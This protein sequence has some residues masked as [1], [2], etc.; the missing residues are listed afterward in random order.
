MTARRQAI[1]AEYDNEIIKLYDTV[2]ETTKA[3]VRRME[4][5]DPLSTLDFVRDVVCNV[6]PKGVGDDD[7]IFQHGCDSLQA[8]WIRNSITHVLR[9]SARLDTRQNTQN[10]VYEYPTISSLAQFIFSLVSGTHDADVSVSSRSSAMQAMV[11][12]YGQHFPIH[13]TT[14]QQ[15]D[16]K[17]VIVA[18]TTGELGCYLLSVLVADD[19]VAKIYA[20]NRSSQWEQDLRDRQIV[21]L[22]DRGLDPDL[23]KRSLLEA[24]IESPHFN[25][26]AAVYQEVSGVCIYSNLNLMLSSADAAKCDPYHSQR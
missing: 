26:G 7:D 4:A 8:T 16:S 2:E 24:D 14:G 20:L 5:W 15:A 25:L 13:G 11:I 22:I 6:M 19:S 10:F 9:D 23:L 18:G 21:A 3:G 12:K 17:V 1:I